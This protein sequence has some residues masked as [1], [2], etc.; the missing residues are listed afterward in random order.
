[1]LPYSSA[2]CVTSVGAPVAESVLLKK[3][4]RAWGFDRTGT[5]VTQRLLSLLPRGAHSTEDD[6]EP[7]WWCEKQDVLTWKD[8]RIA[9]ESE[10]SRRRIYETARA[11][12]AVIIQHVLGASGATPRD[13]LARSVCRMVGMT[14]STAD[15]EA[16]V[17][18]QVRRMIGSGELAEVDGRIRV[19]SAR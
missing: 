14:R 18:K 5:K 12:I 8:F 3:A 13:E 16:R 4:A 6:E 11:E 10:S 1:M 17:L 7:F 9:G 15:A 19:R 2:A